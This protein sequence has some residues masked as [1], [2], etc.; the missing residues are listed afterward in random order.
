MKMLLFLCSYQKPG[1][2]SD[3]ILPRTIQMLPQKGSH[4]ALL[5]DTRSRT[6][7]DSEPVRGSRSAASGTGEN[8]RNGTSANV[9]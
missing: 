8:L 1:G 9:G 3:I 7:A 5:H 6:H 4:H 2:L